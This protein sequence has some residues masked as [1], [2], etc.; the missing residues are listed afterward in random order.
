MIDVMTVSSAVRLLEKKG[1][2]YRSPHETDTRANSISNTEEG[3]NC[4]K[5]AVIDVE[6]VDKT[7]FF[8]N[9][10]ENVQFQN[11]LTELLS[12]NLE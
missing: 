8:E 7:F 10:E 9:I 3:K 4:L 5:R 6:G 11:M 1:L 2:I 12:K